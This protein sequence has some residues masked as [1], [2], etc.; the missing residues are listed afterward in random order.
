MSQFMKNIEESIKEIKVDQ[1]SHIIDSNTQNKELSERL[2]K[3]ERKVIWIYAWSAGAA[4]VVSLIL[5]I[6]F[7]VWGNIN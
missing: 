4:G 7:N 5:Y 6:L 1:S 2:E 3:L